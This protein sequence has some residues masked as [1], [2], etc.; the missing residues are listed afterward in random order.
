MMQGRR[1]E[2]N[3]DRQGYTRVMLTSC[4]DVPSPQ[5]RSEGMGNFMY[6][7]QS[8]EG[9]EQLD[10]LRSQ[11]RQQALGEVLWFAKLGLAQGEHWPELHGLRC[12]VGRGSQVPG[13][14][15]CCRRCEGVR[16]PLAFNESFKHFK[17]TFDLL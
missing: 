17:H 14:A 6:F 2:V 11:Q 8:P 15:V 7:L 4:A 3:G 5:E 9:Q 12:C 16:Q 1:D 13:T 10:C